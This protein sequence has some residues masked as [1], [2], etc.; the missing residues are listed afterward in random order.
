MSRWSIGVDARDDRVEVEALGLEHLLAAEGE[1]LLSE[2]RRTLAGR[3]DELDIAPDGGV[4]V[5]SMQH[6]GGAPEDDGEQVVEV[7]RDTAGEPPDRLD[8]LG[9]M[10]PRL[11]LP[12]G[13]L[14]PLAIG[15]VAR[16]GDDAGGTPGVVPEKRG[17]GLDPDRRAIAVA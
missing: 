3:V 10:E 15:D 9:L 6:G 14:R 7:V 2:L 1:E 16:D 13:G 8:P 12:E 11:G 4:D 5:A 17:R